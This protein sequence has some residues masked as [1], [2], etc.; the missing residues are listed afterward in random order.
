MKWLVYDWDQRRV[1]DVYVPGPDVEETFVFEAVAKFIEQ[2]PADVV[3]VKLDRAGDLVST[4]SDWND[5]RAWIPFYPPRTDFPRRVPTIRRRDLTE[6]DRLGL[7][8]DLATY[9]DPDPS[10]PGETRKVVFKYYLAENSVVTRWHEANCVLRMPSHP[11][12][13]PFDALVVDRIEHVDRVVGFTT[14]YVQGGTLHQNN[15]R[16]FKLKY[17]QQLINVRDM[18]LTSNPPSSYNILYRIRTDHPRVLFPRGI[19][20]RR[21]GCVQADEEGQMDGAQRRK[22]RQPRHRVPPGSQRLG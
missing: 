18:I 14:R 16:V 4:S 15:D 7:Q 9:P 22:A 17:L 8:V 2:L 20:P 13:V 5:D 19:L 3:E 10:R 1:V 11:N 6:V 21:A 12:I